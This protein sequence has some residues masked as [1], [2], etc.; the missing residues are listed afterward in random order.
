MFV[1]K[2]CSS[3]FFVK[4]KNT[5]RTSQVHCEI[6]TIQLLSAATSL[7]SFQIDTNQNFYLLIY[8]FF[9]HINVK[10]LSQSVDSPLIIHLNINIIGTL[11]L[12]LL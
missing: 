8:F 11:L 6:C 9:L 4:N 7:N 1:E 12:L 2:K 3:Y 10:L 5:K